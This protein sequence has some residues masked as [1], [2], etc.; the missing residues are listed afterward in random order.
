MS[1]AFYNG[2]AYTTSNVAGTVTYYGDCMMLETNWVDD[3][4][5]ICVPVQDAVSMPSQL[6]NVCGGLVFYWTS[7]GGNAVDCSEGLKIGTATLTCINTNCSPNQLSLNIDVP[8]GKTEM[9]FFFYPTCLT[10][11]CLRLS[12]QRWYTD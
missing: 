11:G 6:T 9:W 2:C 10:N 7:V 1:N 4:V 12:Y 8:L 5:N 3:D